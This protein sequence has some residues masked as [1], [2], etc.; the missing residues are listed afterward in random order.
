MAA[1]VSKAHE[2]VNFSTYQGRRGPPERRKRQKAYFWLQRYQLLLRQGLL[3][4]GLLR[5]ELPL[6]LSRPLGL[7]SRLS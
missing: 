5:Q 7:L 3:R 6:Q 4:R 1:G 2:K